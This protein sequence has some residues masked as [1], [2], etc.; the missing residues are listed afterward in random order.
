MLHYIKIV[1]RY[2]TSNLVDIG[3]IIKILVT[4]H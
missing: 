4:L 3:Y 2:S 1:F